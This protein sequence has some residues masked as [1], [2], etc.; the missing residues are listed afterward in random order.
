MDEAKNMETSATL[1]RLAMRARPAG[2]PILHQN[3]ENL[4]FLHWP[5][6][7]GFIRALIPEEL[8]V[9]TYDGRAW[10][11]ITPFAVTGLRLLSM[12]PIPALNSF[13]EL[14]VRTYVHSKGIPGIWFF[15][16]DASKLIAALAARVFF[17]LP[18][19]NAEIDFTGAGQEFGFNSKRLLPP[20]ATFGARWHTGLRLRD[21]D[22]DSL[23]FF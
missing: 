18:Y 4:L 14:N 13:D 10:I 12:P 21:P 1:D 9:D 19:H 5:I 7:P 8:E 23:A 3:W 22:Q 20:S 16:L 6:E 11:G 15:S 2:E 17:G